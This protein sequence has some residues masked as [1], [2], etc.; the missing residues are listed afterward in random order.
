MDIEVRRVLTHAETRAREPGLEPA[1]F[2]SMY[3]L[4]VGIIMG[5]VAAGGMSEAEAQE[6]RAHLM[7]M[8]IIYQ[9]THQTTV[10]R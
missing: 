3:A 1:E 5:A 8:E 4:C 7:T 2:A 9:I 10:L 6:A